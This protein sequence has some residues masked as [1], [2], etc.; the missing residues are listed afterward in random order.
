VYNFFNLAIQLVSFVQ[1]K[2]EKQSEHIILHYFRKGKYAIRAAGQICN[3]YE[4][5]AVTN[6]VIQ[7]FARFRKGEFELENQ[8]RPERLVTTNT[9]TVT[10]IVDENLHFMLQEIENNG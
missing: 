3:V 7:M 2:I 8:E 1:N 10:T 9:A 5:S 4:T 6:R